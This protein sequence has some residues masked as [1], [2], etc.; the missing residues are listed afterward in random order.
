MGARYTLTA[1]LERTRDGVAIELLDRRRPL[2]AAR[3]VA[4][5]A[6]LTRFKGTLDTARPEQ[7]VGLDLATVGPARLEHLDGIHE[8]P[9]AGFSDGRTL[10]S[11][12]L[13]GGDVSRALCHEY[14]R[15]VVGNEVTLE[16]GISAFLE[17]RPP[18][19]SQ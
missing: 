10:R 14:E 1:Q 15:A 5:P 19:W 8:C 16:E 4:L 9:I 12:E 7:L 13:V 18:D 11:R 3:T 17:K 6:A 2:G